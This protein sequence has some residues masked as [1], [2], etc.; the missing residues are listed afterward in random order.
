MNEREKLQEAA[1]YIQQQ[2]GDL[3]Q[4]GMIL[5][6][7]LGSLAEEAED[8]VVIPYKDIPHFPVST[9]E[10]HAGQLVCGR[11]SGKQ[12]L[13]LQG[14]FHYYEG[15]S[16]QEV[17][18]PVRVMRLLGIRDLLITNAAG[19]ISLDFSPG[20]LMVITD[21]IKLSDSS[22]L[23]GPNVSEFG[24]RFNDL[25]QAYSRD[26]QHMAD[27]AA[28][29]TGTSLQHGVYA[30]MG[31]PSFET[32]AEIRM[33]RVLGADAVGMS[34]APEVITAAH[35]G[36]RVLGISCITN[37]AAGILPEPL[38]HEEVMETGRMAREKF[39]S[40]IRELLARWEITV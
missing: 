32:P 25:T 2:L 10:G 14:R 16:M 38:N 31:G 40:L 9:V 21:H 20:D 18:I 4:V 28:E 27:Q 7:G 30:F 36:M 34:T 24:L 15:Y 6:S 13:I 26:L 12:V 8:P 5:G 1:S 37:M 19:G 23:R 33:L 29:T 11:I 22:P 39:S 3:P 35:A 17:V